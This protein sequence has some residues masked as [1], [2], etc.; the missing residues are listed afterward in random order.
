ML[1]RIAVEANAAVE[2][3]KPEGNILDDEVRVY[4]EEMVGTGL[5]DLGWLT[6]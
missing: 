5:N 1:H 2:F 6:P 3:T 4:L